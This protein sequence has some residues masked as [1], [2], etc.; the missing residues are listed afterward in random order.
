L[1]IDAVLIAIKQTNGKIVA[2]DEPDI[3]TGREALAR[4]GFY[5]EPTSAVIWNAL[6]QV[7]DLLI[8]PVV[9][10]L[11]GTGLKSP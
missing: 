2:V 4:L 7:S 11:T 6:K 9:V 8:D 5:V 1:R 3:L 10:I